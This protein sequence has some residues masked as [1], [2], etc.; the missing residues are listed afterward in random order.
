MEHKDKQEVSPEEERRKARAKIR[1]I[2]IWAF[3]VLSLLAVFGLLS[4][5]ALSK[6]K[7]KQA[8]VD[9]CVKNVPFSEKWQADL[10]TAGLEGQ[11]ERVINDYCICMWDEPLEKLSEKQIQSLSSI[12]P[13]EQLNLLGGVQAFEARDKQCVASLT[14]R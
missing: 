4:N 14:A 10:K 2:R 1:T 13:Q 9:S 6:P 3:I 11:S 7:A 5:C 8:I 12:S